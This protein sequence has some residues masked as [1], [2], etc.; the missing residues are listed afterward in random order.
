MILLISNSNTLHLDVK[1]KISMTKGG[2]KIPGIKA[3][4]WATR[5]IYPTQAWA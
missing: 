2:G 3:V 4:P 1:K 5:C